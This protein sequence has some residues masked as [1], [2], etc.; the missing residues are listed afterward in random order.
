MTEALLDRETYQKSPLI[1]QQCPLSI[2]SSGAAAE[3]SKIKSEEEKCEE[4]NLLRVDL[5][6]ISLNILIWLSSQ[7]HQ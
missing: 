4:N 2:V 6:N 3:K 1:E 5:G 7:E